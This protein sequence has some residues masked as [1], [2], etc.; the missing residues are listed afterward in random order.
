MPSLDSPLKRHAESDLEGEPPIK[1]LE[2]LHLGST[3]SADEQAKQQD[4]LTDSDNVMMLDDTKHTSY[5]YDIERELASIEAEEKRISF[6]PDIEK[7]LNAIPKSILSEPKP[8]QNELVLYRVPRSLTVAE[9]QD[10]V[11]KAII[12]S[13]ARA[14]ARHTER[15]TYSPSIVPPSDDR[16]NLVFTFEAD[17]VMDV[18]SLQ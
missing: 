3:V 12:E 17:D 13:R 11:R 10:N 6:L 7:A 1:K 4:E 8:E 5:I 14:R 9:D 18:D 2:L 16:D 15:S